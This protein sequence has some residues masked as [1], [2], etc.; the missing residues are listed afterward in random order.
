MIRL[1]CNLSTCISAEI[2]QFKVIASKQLAKNFYGQHE[3]LAGFNLKINLTT[4]LG[5]IKSMR[6]FT[7]SPQAIDKPTSGPL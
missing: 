3:S 4:K 5:G 7:N 1:L 6:M 2:K